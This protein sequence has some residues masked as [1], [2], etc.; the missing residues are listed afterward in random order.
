MLFFITS[1]AEAAFVVNT[2]DART[3]YPASAPVYTSDLPFFGPPATPNSDSQ[4][5]RTDRTQAQTFDVSSPISVESVYIG[6]RSN[7]D[8]PNTVRIRILSIPDVGAAY[9]N[10]TVLTSATVATPAPYGGV[11]ERYNAVRLDWVDTAPL[12]LSPQPGVAGYALELLG[13]TPPGGGSGFGP[14]IAW[15][16]RTNNPYADGRAFTLGSGT[17]NASSDWVLA[18]TGQVIPEPSTF[19]LWALCVG[20]CNVTSR[21]RRVV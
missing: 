10:P 12:I 3:S 15:I 21:R 17:P 6:Y 11:G 20:V 16:F 7:P 8:A 19:V 4:G 14:P 13:Q 2:W 9:T 5:V 18:I 1:S